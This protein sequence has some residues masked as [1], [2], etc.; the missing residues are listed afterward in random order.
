MYIIYMA[1]K[2]HFDL[3][4]DVELE[5]RRKYKDLSLDELAKMMYEK[6]RKR[7]LKLTSADPIYHI[8]ESV[9]NGLYQERLNKFEFDRATDFY[10]EFN[11]QNISESEI[12]SKI[13]HLVRL[14]KAL[15]RKVGRLLFE[16]TDFGK[17]G[18]DVH[19]V[20]LEKETVNRLENISKPTT[21][22]IGER[23]LMQDIPQANAKRDFLR[24]LK[25]ISE[26][27]AQ[28]NAINRLRTMRKMHA[29]RAV[30]EEQLKKAQARRKRFK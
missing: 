18:P 27:H 9:L 21:L 12:K 5:L 2:N 7:E 26:I 3:F 24:I 1:K 14:K 13:D 16:S 11:K 29:E 20:D 28:F 17:T 19:V 25:E 15:N 8:Q 4:R 23:F 10:K 30:E 22:T 6:H